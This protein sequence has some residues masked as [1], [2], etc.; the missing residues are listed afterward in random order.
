MRSVYMDCVSYAVIN[1]LHSESFHPA[2]DNYTLIHKPAVLPMGV[3]NLVEHIVIAF[4][5]HLLRALGDFLPL[6]CHLELRVQSVFLLSLSLLHLALSFPL[7][8][9]FYLLLHRFSLR[10]TAEAV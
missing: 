8:F 1:R 6:L 10:G 4:S 5:C 7:L 3:H 2:G 9:G